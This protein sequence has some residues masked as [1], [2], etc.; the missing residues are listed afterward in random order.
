M[1]GRSTSF[2]TRG[3]RLAATFS[4]AVAVLTSSGTS[5]DPG[6][7]AGVNYPASQPDTPTRRTVEKQKFR[8][9]AG[10]L[11]DRHGQSVSPV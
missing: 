7:R 11:Q 10:L 1:T 3:H 6:L 9:Y 8:H 4:L 5:P 2:Y